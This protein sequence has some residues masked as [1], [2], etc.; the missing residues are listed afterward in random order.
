M[1]KRI[2]GWKAAPMLVFGAVAVC[3]GLTACSE[4]DQKTKSEKIYAGKKDSRAYEGEK[5]A[6]DQKKWEAALAER[7]KVQNEYLRTDVKK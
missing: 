4:V 1:M 2:S 3:F 7:S 5:F 6:N